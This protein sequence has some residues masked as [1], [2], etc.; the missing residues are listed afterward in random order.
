[1]LFYLFLFFLFVAIFIAYI[2]SLPPVGR[3]GEKIEV[4]SDLQEMP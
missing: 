3:S 2:K 4:L 1:M